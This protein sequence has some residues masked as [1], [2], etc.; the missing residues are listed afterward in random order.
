MRTLK[1]VLFLAVLAASL[2]PRMAHA[3]LLRVTGG[4]TVDESFSFT[5]EY[6]PIGTVLAASIAFDVA[7]TAGTD[8]FPIVGPASGVV[9]WDDGVPRTFTV[10][11]A[12]PRFVTGSGLVA[13]LYTGVGPTIHSIDPLGFSVAFDVGKRLEL[14]TDPW[15]ELLLGSSV[16]SMGV[17][18]ERDRS[19]VITQV[20]HENPFGTVTVPGPST[21]LLLASGLVL[22]GRRR[23]RSSH[24]GT[25]PY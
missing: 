4:A 18:L 12:R 6:L 20:A 16:S 25:S 24:R 15:D 3:T 13:V 9:T 14:A 21:L 19:F 17:F 2:A 23:W 11:L 8:I 7:G 1:R 5:D 22:A 10:T